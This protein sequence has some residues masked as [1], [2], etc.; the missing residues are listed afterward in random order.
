MSPFGDGYEEDIFVGRLPN[1]FKKMNDE[2]DSDSDCD[3]KINFPTRPCKKSCF[4]SS[5][6]E[7]SHFCKICKDFYNEHLTDDLYIISRNL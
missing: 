2:T 1:E 3:E 5:V 7:Y 4:T 6:L